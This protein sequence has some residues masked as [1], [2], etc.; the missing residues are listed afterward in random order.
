LAA[1]GRRRFERFE[2][3][4]GMISADS[5]SHPSES[6]L[7]NRRS[8]ATSERTGISGSRKMQNEVGAAGTAVVPPQL[9]NQ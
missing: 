1:F 4:K 5:E 7:D 9:I 2:D 8:A 3:V 6:Q